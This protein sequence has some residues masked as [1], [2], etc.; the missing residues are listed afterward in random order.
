MGAPR[1]PACELECNETEKKQSTRL[2]RES[3]DMFA[4]A[5]RSSPAVMAI[6]DLDSTTFCDVNDT[7]VELFGYSRDEIIGKPSTTVTYW[8][9]K[10]G[11]QAIIEALKKTGSVRDRLV[12]TRTRGGELRVGFWSGELVRVAGRARVICTWIDTTQVERLEEELARLQQRYR[13]VSELTSDYAYCLR[14]ADDGELH[15]EWVAGDEAALTGYQWREIERR[16][17]WQTIVYPDDETIPLEQLRA[18]LNGRPMTVE[19]RI[20]TK[21][22]E[23]RWLRDSV[24][25][26]SHD[27]ESQCTHIYGAVQDITHRRHAQEALRDSEER[28]RSLL[29]LIPDPVVIIQ[30]GAF[31]LANRAFYEIFGYS[32][33]EVT[34]DLRV[35]DLVEE[36]SRPFVL[37]RIR[38]ELTGRAESAAYQIDLLAKDGH[39]VPTEIR[40]STIQYDK[41]PAVLWVARDNSA[42]LAAAQEKALLEHQLRQAQKMEAVGQLAG[43]VAH[44]MN[45]VLG[46]V[47]G[48]ASLM[49]ASVPEHDPLRDDLDKILAATSRGAALTRNLLGFAR[50]GRHSTEI[51]RLDKTI[52]EVEQLLA[53]TI[54]KQVTLSSHIAENIPAVEGDAD[55]LLQALI[56]VCLNAVHAVRDRGTIA[57]EVDTTQL[58]RESFTKF[59]DLP[60]GPYAR[61]RIRDD[62]CGMDTRTVERAFEP[63]FTTKSADQGTGLG[64]AMVYG[65]IREHSGAVALESSPGSGTTVTLLLP[66]CRF[67]STSR[68]RTQRPRTR[69]ETGTVL[70][71]D[72][73]EIMRVVGERMLQMN[74]FRVLLAEHGAAALKILNEH[75]GEVDVVVLDLSMPV[76]SGPECL[77]RLHSMDPTLPVLICTGYAGAQ[78]S[79]ELLKRGAAGLVTKPYDISSLLDAVDHAFAMRQIDN[80]T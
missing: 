43:G 52:G 65:T 54:P 30:E 78:G 37:H 2:L 33:E 34:S 17:G 47:M 63:F 42:S 64:L 36:H 60:P 4:K 12:Q 70:I 35:T 62:G 31:R 8:A 22:G 48:V 23:V 72:D 5:F 45:N 38:E 57:I 29:E 77:E 79:E 76:M 80:S 26:V 49:C 46:M 1:A 71:V 67:K 44:D 40:S 7:F 58:S 6:L 21:D 61:I 68:P 55:Q 19:Y 10:S 27:K 73:E 14:V 59:P 25:P 16:G 41:R 3:E 39:Q 53:S 18:A 24:R 50:R 32:C 13:L 28:Y 75:P 66:A 20:V 69:T 56:N 51:V 9:D 15:G 74:G 11:R